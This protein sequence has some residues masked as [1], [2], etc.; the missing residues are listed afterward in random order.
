[1]LLGVFL[2][3]TPFLRGKRFTDTEVLEA[4]ERSLRTFFGKRGEQVVQDN[5]MAV[6]RGYEE[7][8]EIP[9]EIMTEALVAS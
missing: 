3:A 7:V 2:R 8:R 9:W 1:V 4:V 6:R 5:L